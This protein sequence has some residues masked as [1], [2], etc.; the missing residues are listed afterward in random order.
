MNTLFSKADKVLDMYNTGIRMVPYGKQYA[1]DTIES[2]D[3][4]ETAI[5]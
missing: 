3:T 2:E 4:N 1:L 5:T